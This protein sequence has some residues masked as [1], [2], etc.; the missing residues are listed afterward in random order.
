MKEFLGLFKKS[1][2][3]FV[4]RMSG[5]LLAFIVTF[6]Y[7]KWLGAEDFGLFILGLTLITVF[8]VISR[9]GLDQ[10]VLKNIAIFEQKFQQ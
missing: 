7:A 3:A 1:F 8:S 6:V 10:V 9:L 5:A 2:Y 4:A